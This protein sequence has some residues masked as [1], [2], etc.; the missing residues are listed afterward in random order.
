MINVQL[1]KFEGPLALLLYL[2]R[3][4]EMDVLDIN[5]NEITKQYFEYIKVMKELDL[6]FAGDFVAMAA[7]LIQ[8]KA[9]MLLPTYNEAGEE[10]EGGDP[11]RELVQKL[12]EYEKYQE[13]AKVL[14]ERPLLGRDIWVRGSCESLPQV[15]GGIV[16][17]DN[18]LFSLISSYRRAMHSMKRQVHKVAIKT[19]SVASRIIEI[20]DRLL[21]GKQV[22]MSS[23]I[24]SKESESRLK[25]SLITFLSILELGKLQMIKIFQS[26][27]YEEIYVE[28]CQEINTDA[29]SR[30]EEYETNLE[31]AAR[32]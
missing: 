9:R 12:L 10:I 17:E 25:E 32:I 3:K 21:L 24:Q 22:P 31:A 30:V 7:T 26:A 6:E 16:V 23:L 1:Q 5:I 29:I 18:A 28:G 8:I 20:K 4:E 15:E 27:T 11:R 14:Y 13:A 19:Q 2:I